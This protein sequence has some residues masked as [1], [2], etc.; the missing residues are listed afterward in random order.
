MNRVARLLCNRRLFLRCL[1]AVGA[2]DGAT[3]LCIGDARA[4][5]ALVRSDP[6]RRAV[7]I[8]PPSSVRLWFNEDIEQDYSSI[9]VRDAAGQP[10]PTGHAVI[11]PTDARLLLLDLP[12]LAP[13]QYTVHYR[14]NSV[15]GHVVEASYQFTVK[16]PPGGK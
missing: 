3:L 13:G 8:R 11:S 10:I 2:V 12:V 1:L 16:L 6:S 14:V 15:D 5:A 4:H 9:S 7:L